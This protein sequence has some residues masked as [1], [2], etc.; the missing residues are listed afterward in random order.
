MVL[1]VLLNLLL[2]V[3]VSLPS[4]PS[5]IAYHRDYFYVGGGYAD[6]G[7]GEHIFKGQ[8]YVEHLTP[9]GGSRRQ[10]PLLFIHGQAQTG[11]VGDGSSIISTYTG[12]TVAFPILVII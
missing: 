3:A 5:E 8:M 1:K 2:Q 7:K 6:N 4:T 11:T 12:Y 10:H 9:V